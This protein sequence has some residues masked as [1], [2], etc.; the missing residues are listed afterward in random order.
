[1]K[2]FRAIFKDLAKTKQLER[3]HVVQRAICI[4][5]EY[6]DDAVKVANQIIRSGFSP[7]T[8]KKKLDNGR[9]P[10]DTVAVA[11]R[12]AQ[13]ATET[14]CETEEERKRF[15]EV[16]K[17]LYK[18]YEPAPTD[19]HYIYIFVRQDISP[20]YQLVQASHA[21]AKMGHRSGALS[22]SFFDELYFAV[23]GVHDLSE[24]AVALNDCKELGVTTYPFYE[25]D[26]GNVM[27][28]FA[29]APIPAGKRKR[30]L[31]YKKLRFK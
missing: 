17:E 10:Y 29:T 20:E 6:G 23:I 30:L 26:I 12:E 25:P 9:L 3:W 2:N 21:A 7:I 16:L 8:R 18:S 15:H 13:W 1:M 11:L 14:F 24:M 4:G 22:Q 5:M 19:R 31:S 28:A 27:T